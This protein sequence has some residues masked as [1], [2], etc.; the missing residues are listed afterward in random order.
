MQSL[1]PILSPW[2]TGWFTVSWKA[3]R[4]ALQIFDQLI[5]TNLA[6]KTLSIESIQSFVYVLIGTLGR[7]FQELK[8]SPE[9]LLKE[10]LNFKYLYEHWNDSVTITTLRHAI[11]DILTAVNCRG[12]TNDE[13]LLNEMIHYIHT[14]YTDDIMLNDMADQFN[15]SPKILRNSVQT[16]ERPELQRLSKPLPN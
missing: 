13:K 1:I 16:A 8:T 14:N 2:R 10:D 11:Q 5:R 3:K 12:E 7:V 6:D 15:I 9:A 4:E